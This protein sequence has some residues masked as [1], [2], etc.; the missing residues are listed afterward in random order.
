[1]TSSHEQLMLAIQNETQKFQEFYVWMEQAMPPTFFEEVSQENLMLI[2]HSLIGFDLQEFFSTIHLKSAAI[3]ICLDSDDA[4]LRILKNYALFGIKNYQTF[5][6]KIPPPFK[7]VTA[8][9]RIAFIDFTGVDE[10][11]SKPYPEEDKEELRALVKQRNPELQDKEFDSLVSSINTRFLRSMPI[12][13]LIL[14][15]DM[16][17]RAKTRDNC[18]YEVRYTENWEERNT[19]SMQIVLAW[20]NTP[21]HHF[22]YRIARTIHRHGL[23]MKRVNAAYVDPYSKQNIL[24]MSLSLHGANGKAAW[25]VANIPDFLRELVTVKYFA[26][27]DQIDDALVSKG[28]ISGN[29]GNVLRAMVN[30]VHQALVN[31]DPNIY[32]I[33]QIEEAFCRHPELSQRICEAFKLKF[34]RDHHDYE[35]YLKVREAFIKDVGKLD[36]GQEENDL[37]RKNVLLQAMN[38]IHHCYKTNAYRTNF[39]A[40]CFRMDPKYLDEIPFKRHDKFPELPY[41]IYFM[42]GMHFFGFHIRFKDLSR[43]GLRTVFPD[44]SEHLIAERNN[45]FTECYNLAWTQHKKNKDIPEGGAKGIIF[46]KPY[47]RLTSE[48][49]IFEKEMRNANIETAEIQTRIDTFQ[50]EQKTEYLYQTQRS[51]IEALTTIVNCE[52]DGRLRARHIVDYWKRPEYLYLG[53]DENMHDVMIEWIAEYSKRHQYRPGSSFISGKPSVGINHKEYGVTSLGLNVYMDRLLRYLGIDPEKEVFTV[54]MTGGPDGDVAGNQIL[55][56]FK[57]YPRT[58]KLV[59]LT[60]GTGTIYDPEGLDLEVLSN[61]FR[62]VKGIKHYP[63]ELLHDNGF[64]LDKS[65]RR[66]QTKISQQTLCSRKINGKVI[67]DWL[68]GND[69]NYLLRHNVHQT[70]ADVFLPCGGRP[71]TLNQSNVQDYLDEM[72][73]PTSRGIVEGANLYLNEGARNFLEDKGVLIIKDSSANKTGVICSSFEILSGLTL[74]DELFMKHK[75]ALTKEILARLHKAASNEADLL[76]RTREKTGEPLTIISDRISQRINEFTYQILDHLDLQPLPTDG[77]HPLLNVFFSYCPPTL[78]DEY[79]EKLLEQIPEHHKKAIIA[80]NIG[81]QLVYG[82]GLNWFPSIVDI[83]P[84]LLMHH[85][86]EI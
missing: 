8:N 26:S 32:T 23:V 69:M 10:K 58:A 86:V 53:P 52:P 29:M 56:L 19:A 50:H 5:V 66:S 82:K 83:L 1:M 55:N 4:D 74:G 40:F 78:T 6:S 75:D 3:A 43:G 81:A 73:K 64:L 63:P 30:F 31:I 14:V 76:I 21:K 84:F 65:R 24:L 79:K 47:E 46:L 49:L 45:V 67:E 15:M 80:A 7:G 16:F 54:K 25:D 28:T 13:R 48:S 62:S 85:D 38:M 9:L 17:F 20:R 60:D 39:T 70:Y 41:A 11:S 59:A 44:Q 51:Y 36:T 77:K 68:A 37:R 34:D 35:Q 27:F 72:G 33:E 61:L 18:Q 2:A 42:K 12:D 71:R 22:L 57:Y